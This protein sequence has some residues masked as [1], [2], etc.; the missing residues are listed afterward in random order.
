MICLPYIGGINMKEW[1]ILV[2][3]ITIILWIVLFPKKEAYTYVFQESIEVETYEVSISGAVHKPGTYIIYGPMRLEEIIV[4]AFGFTSDAD[5]DR[6]D[7]NKTYNQNSNIHIPS[8]EEEIVVVQKININKANFQTLL[9]IPGIQERQAAAI[10]VYREA[11]GLFSTLD[12]LLNVTYIGPKTLEKLQ[13][14]LSL[15]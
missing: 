15:G 11:N 12:E 9:T 14:Y 10:I 7:L 6:I 8:L 1:M 13:P 3:I 4:F 5:L 2:V